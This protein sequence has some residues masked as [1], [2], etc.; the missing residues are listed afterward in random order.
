MLSYAGEDFC[1][2]C[3]TYATVEPDLCHLVDADPELEA[4]RRAWRE[5]CDGEDIVIAEDRPADPF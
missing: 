1:D 5:A 2:A 3:W 4:E